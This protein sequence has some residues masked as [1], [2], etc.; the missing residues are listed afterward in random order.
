VRARH[1]ETLA[2]VVNALSSGDMA[3]EG[4]F[5]RFGSLPLDVLPVQRPYPP[6]WYAGGVESAASGGFNLLTRSAAE[7]AR[8]WQLC[9]ASRDLPGRVNGH[10]E[11]PRVAITRH[12]V[13]RESYDAAVALARRSWPVFESH[14]F[15]TPI[16]LNEDGRPAPQQ[17]S[18]GGSDF[19][20][21]LTADRRLIVGTPAMVCERLLAWR[22]E[23]MDHPDFDFTP[24]VQ[25]GDITT[26]EALET[27][28]L[29][30]RDVMPYLPGSPAA[31]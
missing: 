5:Y 9:E 21:A 8:Y 22:E 24:A 13:V 18:A 26:P 27:L 28:A 4:R 29:L 23:L 11:A 7:A 20:D 16:A 10:L 6:L 2:I 15:A 17:P 30:A 3:Y 31:K 25:W 1:D 14:W 19:D 12:V